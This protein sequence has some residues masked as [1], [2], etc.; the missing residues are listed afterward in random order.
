MEIRYCIFFTANL[1][2]VVFQVGSILRIEDD[3]KENARQFHLQIL[4][5]FDRILK[6]QKENCAVLLFKN[7]FTPFC[8]RAILKI[9]E[10]FNI[11]S[12]GKK[13]YHI[14]Y[15]LAI[16]RPFF[17]KFECISHTINFQANQNG[18]FLILDKF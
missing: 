14:K 1:K 4:Y 8:H 3:L 16:D 18:K 6:S 11:L 10:N 7:E 12:D 2:R 17:R 9:D 15:D 13:E 5:E